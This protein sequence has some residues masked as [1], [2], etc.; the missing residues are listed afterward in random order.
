LLL[1]LRHHPFSRKAARPLRP[2]FR[3]ARRML[4]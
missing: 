1:K 4:S 2:L 3:R